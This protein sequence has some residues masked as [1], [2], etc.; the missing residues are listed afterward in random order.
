MSKSHKNRLKQRTENE[1]IKR[2]KAGAFEFVQKINFILAK[3]REANV[4]IMET[5]PNKDPNKQSISRVIFPQDGGVLTY[6]DG[7]DLPAKGFC[8]GETVE[9]VDEVKKT[10]IAFL[11]GFFKGLKHNKVKMV[12]F[13]LLFRKQFM[14]IFTSLIKRLDFRMRRVRQKP[15]MYCLCAREIYRVFNLMMV[16]Y[17][18]WKKILE[19]LRNIVCMILE[20]DDA[21]RYPLQDALP[22]FNSDAGRKDIVKELGRVL[23]FEMKWDHKVGMVRKLKQ[24]KKLLFLLKFNKKLREAVTRFFLEVDLNRMKMD[25]A[26]KFH[27]RYKWGY[28]WDHIGEDYK[29]K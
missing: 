25:K 15:E 13:I 28:D 20:Y 4:G 11:T 3:I 7:V 17:P 27:A 1:R 12:L 22:E 9:T 19:C 26:D 18:F 21:Y 2:Q 8:Y 29:P 10:G 23:D 5:K 24:I 6:F 16:W 14:T